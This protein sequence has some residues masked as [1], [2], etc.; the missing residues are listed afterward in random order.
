MKPEVSLGRIVP[1]KFMSS[2]YVNC[3]WTVQDNH[4]SYDEHYTVG[5]YTPTQ[6]KISND[7]QSENDTIVIVLLEK[8]F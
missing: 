2:K 6:D 8:T 3:T 1:S 4:Q 7:E 5:N